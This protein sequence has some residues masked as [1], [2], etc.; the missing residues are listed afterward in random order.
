MATRILRNGIIIRPP[1]GRFRREHEAVPT[2]VA[3][4]S[5][6]AWTTTADAPNAGRRRGECGVEVEIA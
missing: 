1:G 6:V 5:T 3:L 4:I 2:M